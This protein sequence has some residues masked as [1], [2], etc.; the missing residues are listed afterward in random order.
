MNPYISIYKNNPTAGGT[1]G[2]AVSQDGSMVE[3]V[4]VTL[5][6]SQS[7]SEVVKLAVRTETG[8]E[9]DGNTTISIE[10]DTEAHWKLDTS[11][12]GSFSSNS[13]TLSSTIDDTNT[14]FYAKA[15]SSSS[16]GPGR[17]DTPQIVVEAKIVMTE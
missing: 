6:A 10:Y 9:T 12:S 7:E 13:I 2:T 14:I 3:P 15:S 4:S 5:D 8:Y 11:S 17:Y 16:E 1:D